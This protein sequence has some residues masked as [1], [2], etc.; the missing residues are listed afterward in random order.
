LVSAFLRHVPGGASYELLRFAA[1]GAF[2]LFLSDEVLEEPARSLAKSERSRRRYQYSDGDIVE[3]C[4]DLA[5]LGAV[6][7]DIPKI[8]GV[9]RDPNDDMVVACAIARGVSRKP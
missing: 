6:L 7:A 5:L 2:E 9:V 1:E 4:Q 8:A 3:Y